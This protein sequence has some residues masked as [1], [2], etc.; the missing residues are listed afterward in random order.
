MSDIQPVEAPASN[1]VQPIAVVPG[2]HFETIAAVAIASNLTAAHADLDAEPWKAW[3][4]RAFTKTVR[5]ISKPADARF[6]AELSAAD[7]ASRSFT[8]GGATAYAFAPMGYDDFP[9]R[10]RQLRVAGLDL[11]RD[12]G[13]FGMTPAGHLVRPE[14]VVSNDVQLTTGKTS[15]Q[16]AHALMVWL[17]ELRL[18]GRAAFL[19]WREEP[20]L[21]LCVADLDEISGDPAQSITIVDSGLTEIAPKTATVRVLRP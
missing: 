1:L 9:K 6:I 7:P 8:V 2:T 15:A 5:R 12:G 14:V 17:V 3:L 11:E 13:S 10:L 18:T 4:S 19:A 21:A 20:A 16:V